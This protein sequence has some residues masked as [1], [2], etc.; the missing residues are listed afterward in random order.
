MITIQTN[1]NNNNNSSDPA[2]DAMRID[3]PSFAYQV[4]CSRRYEQY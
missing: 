2:L 4:S 3:G 1:N